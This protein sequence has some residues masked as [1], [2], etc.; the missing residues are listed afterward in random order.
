MGLDGQINLENA[1]VYKT[2]QVCLPEDIQSS[3]YCTV[4][5][6]ERELCTW[7]LSVVLIRKSFLRL[8]SVPQKSLGNALLPPVHLIDTKEA[9]LLRFHRGFSGA[10]YVVHAVCVLPLH[11]YL[12]CVFLKNLCKEFESKYSISLSKVPSHKPRFEGEAFL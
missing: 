3:S 8:S 11:P 2:K 1:R 9:R 12:L 4:H 10:L 7:L 5:L 6:S